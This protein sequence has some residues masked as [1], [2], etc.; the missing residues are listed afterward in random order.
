MQNTRSTQAM[1]M[2][3][4]SASPPQSDCGGDGNNLALREP[5]CVNGILDY[6]EDRWPWVMRR[7]TI[8][9]LNNPHRTP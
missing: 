1:Q 4:A 2:A 6:R 8:S 5:A 3:L 9:M 7:L